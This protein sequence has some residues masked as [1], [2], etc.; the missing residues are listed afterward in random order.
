MKLRTAQFTARKVVY[1]NAQKAKED[2]KDDFDKAKD[3]RFAVYHAGDL[4]WVKINDRKARDKPNPKL[5]A[6]WE[7]GRIVE[8]VKLTAY[9]V[10]RMNRK[11]Q[12]LATLNV[13]QLKPRHLMPPPDRH[14]APVADGA[15]DMPSAVQSLTATQ[16]IE[17]LA[18][19][20]ARFDKQ[21]AADYTEILKLLRIRE[22]LVEGGGVVAAPGPNHGPMHLPAPLPPPMPMPAIPGLQPR[23]NRGR[24]LP[25]PDRP[26]ELQRGPRVPPPPQQ[27]LHPMPGQEPKEAGLQAVHER[28]MEAERRT[29]LG[30]DFNAQFH[31]RL[32]DTRLLPLKLRPI[33]EKGR[34]AQ[35]QE[36]QDR[37]VRLR[38]VPEAEVPAA[39]A[40]ATREAEVPAAP[41]Q[42]TRE[43]EVPAAP[44]QAI[45]EGHVPATLAQAARHPLYHEQFK[46]L[47]HQSPSAPPEEDEW[48][49]PPEHREAAEGEWGTWSQRQGSM[50]GRPLPPV[51]PVPQHAPT[52]T[53]PRA[54]RVNRELRR[55]QDYNAGGLQ[56]TAPHPPSTSA[57]Q[58]TGRPQ[59]SKKAKS[60]LSDL[61]FPREDQNASAVEAAVDQLVGCLER[62]G[63]GQDYLDCV[64]FIEDRQR[65][66]LA[67]GGSPQ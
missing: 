28:F 1:Q 9:R 47:P 65:E 49:T 37:P 24:Q 40:Q 21:T 61:F 18:A 66:R 20:Q 26:A 35:R 57:P 39:P 51:P 16:E 60:R 19:S 29:P 25:V 32:Q 34:P 53:P 56:D 64:T 22:I 23:D 58:G 45:R 3:A 50:R 42:A 27:W 15:E 33:K 38:P 54:P 48:T 8:H 11:R 67:R 6:R 30:P 36:P 44:A 5:A 10:C 17:E 13:Q 12:K 55:L 43:A 4:V 59:R 31:A 2:Y 62:T 41:A 52:P 63:T 7:P 14:H 46:G